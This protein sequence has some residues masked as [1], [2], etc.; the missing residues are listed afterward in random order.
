[1][2]RSDA[3]PGTGAG[4]VGV[5]RGRPFKWLKGSR[6]YFN[7]VILGLAP[8]IHTPGVGSVRTIFERVYGS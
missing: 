5:G 3:R 4:G 1:M 7:I 8:R 6:G 2:A